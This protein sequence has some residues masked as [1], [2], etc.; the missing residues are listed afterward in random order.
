MFAFGLF[1]PHLGVWELPWI[2]PKNIIPICNITQMRNLSFRIMILCVKLTYLLVLELPVQFHWR[3]FHMCFECL[4]LRGR[5][6]NDKHYLTR[7]SLVAQSVKDL[8]AVQ[9]TWVWSLDREDRLKKEM[10][11]HSSILSWRIPW[12]PYIS[13]FI[14]FQTRQWLF[15]FFLTQW[16]LSLFTSYI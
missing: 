5:I 3:C 6:F 15:F 11:T 14:T 16:P 2:F 8:P 7:A 4:R 12:T 10:T 9:E 13:T 1:C